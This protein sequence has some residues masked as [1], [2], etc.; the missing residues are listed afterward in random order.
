MAR[1]AFSRIR[2]SALSIFGAVAA[3]FLSIRSVPPE[4]KIR[5]QPRRNAPM[6]QVRRIPVN[7]TS[8]PPNVN[9]TRSVSL[10]MASICA[11]TPAFW[12]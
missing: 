11:A 7:P 6:T 9:V 3:I 10:V 2:R 4:V 5:L 8:L 12:R 1:G